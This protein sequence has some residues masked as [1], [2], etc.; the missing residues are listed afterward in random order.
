MTAEPASGP[1][2]HRSDDLSSLDDCTGGL[3]SAWEMLLP[4]QFSLRSTPELARSNGLVL[5]LEPNTT[6]HELSTD[7]LWLGPDEWLIAAQAGSVAASVADGI[8][9]RLLDAHHALVDVSATRAVIDLYGPHWRHVLAQGCSIDLDPRRWIAGSCAQTLL[10][11]SPVLL[12]ALSHRITRLYVRASFADHVVDW[13]M[14]ACTDAE[15]LA[16]GVNLAERPARWSKSFSD[17]DRVE[18]VGPE[19]PN[20]PIAPRF[21]EMGL[22][23]PIDPPDQ[24]VIEFEGRAHSAVYSEAY[25]RRILDA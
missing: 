17:G 11:D 4:L 18:W 22:V 16:L 13:L 1:L 25:L 15:I 3:L 5:P 20:Q 24:W 7:V 9:G 6:A 23:G 10:S 19:V 21:G 14:R 2:A 8:R 12:E